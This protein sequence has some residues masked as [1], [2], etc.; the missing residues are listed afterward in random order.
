MARTFVL[1]LCAVTFTTVFLSYT[2]LD[3]SLHSFTSAF[4]GLP[5]GRCACGRCMTEPED[6]PWFTERFNRSIQPLMSRENSALSDET[7]KW[8]QVRGKKTG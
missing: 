1:L 6:D 4:R 5:R 3:S 2:W 8:W 7:F